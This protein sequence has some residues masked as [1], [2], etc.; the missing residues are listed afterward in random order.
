[1]RKLNLSKNFLTDRVGAGLKEVLS[2]NRDLR[3]LYL[4]WNYLKAQAGTDIF[5]GL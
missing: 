2:S 5:Q 3:E 1:M 4:H